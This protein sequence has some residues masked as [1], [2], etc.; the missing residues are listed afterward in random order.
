MPSAD[1]LLRVFCLPCF[2]QRHS[3]CEQ[4]LVS[5]SRCQFRTVTRTDVVLDLLHSV[6][7]VG[8]PIGNYT[9]KHSPYSPHQ[10]TWLTKKEIWT[11]YMEFNSYEAQA[12]IQE[13]HFS[14]QNTH[15]I[16]PK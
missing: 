16:P 15:K 9:P 14:R 12:V 4:Y 10:Y 11:I 3:F 6:K 5:A 13:K 2:V 7:T 1:G 8:G